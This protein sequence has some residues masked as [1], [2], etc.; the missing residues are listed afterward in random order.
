MSLTVIDFFAGAGG[1]MQGAVAVP[2]VDGRL[3]ANH[4]RR[5]IES[6]T[7]NFPDVEHFQGDLHDVD[8]ARFPAGDLFWAS[9]EC[10]TWS[11]ARGQR[12][13]Y[14]K[15]PDLFGETLPDE[16]TDRSRALMWDVPRYLE[17]MRLRGA[18]VLAGVVENVTDV[19]AWNLWREWVRAIASLGYRTR[20][21]A[22]NSMHARP[23]VTPPAP[24]SRDRLYLAYWAVSLGRDPDWDRWLRPDAWCPS[25]D[26]AV[27][28]VQWWKR[29]G[30]DM[31]R[32]RQQYLYRCPRV[33]CR[34]QVV[35]PAAMP[36]AAAIDWSIPGARIGD[37]AVPLKPKTIARIEAGLRRYA[38]PITL[39]AAGNTFERRPGVRTWPVDEPLTTQTATATKAMACPPLMVPAGGTWRDEAAPV[40]VP[41]SARTARENDGLAVPPFLTVN[42]GGQDDLRT[43]AVTAPLAS[44]TA[45]SQPFGLVTPAMLVP[46][47]GR[48][49]KETL[50]VS[51]PVRTQTARAETGLAVPP[52]ITELRGT[53]DARPITDPLMTVAASGNHHALITPPQMAMIM[54]NNTARGDEGQMST[55]ASEPLRTL[56]ALG[57]QSLITWEHLAHLL[58][59]Y[60]GTGVA[61]AVTEPAG[62]VTT[63]D[64]FGLASM[65]V[66]VED[67]LFRMLE[68]HEIG[69]AMAFATAYQV[70]GSKREKVRQYG[71]AV[72]PPVAEVIISALVEAITGAD[73]E[74]AA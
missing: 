30:N 9:P 63:A 21:I 66:S 12:R 48:D 74:P 20:L 4:W 55:P 64:R 60:Y 31:G 10:P 47:E 22:I 6:H 41:M 68:P 42:R 54:R 27:T 28:A 45:S 69:A 57:H 65:A 18:P 32:Y 43:S 72:T 3:A 46:V 36:A 17:G 38:R 1:S 70:L 67:V 7:A 39:E 49:G 35:E 24:Q 59:P 33:A 5:A 11:Q 14:D 15:Q 62:T 40:T 51:D 19:R 23:R 34:G 53:Q 44:L 50:P 73:L 58:V 71:N 26:Q 16:A 29:P 37:R 52:F 61:R 25:C 56:T 8:V 13:D 2:G